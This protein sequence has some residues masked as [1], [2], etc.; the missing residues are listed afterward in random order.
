MSAPRPEEHRRGPNGRCICGAVPATDEQVGA[1]VIALRVPLAT[2]GCGQPTEPRK[3]SCRACLIR[4]SLHPACVICGAGIP[5]HRWRMCDPC[6][7]HGAAVMR[8]AWR[9][10]A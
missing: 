8:A 5:A 1:H 7:F 10:A 2:C 9:W 3:R 4:D 6:A